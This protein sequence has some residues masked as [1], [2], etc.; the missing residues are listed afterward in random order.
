MIS[1]KYP[2]AYDVTEL[3]NLRTTS[4]PSVRLFA[5][6]KG[7]LIAGRGKESISS[8]LN[9]LL[10]DHQSYLDLRYYAQGGG[11]RTSISGFNI[12]D[13]STPLKSL[14]DIYAD[15]MRL[16]RNLAEQK[17]N[18]PG[19]KSSVVEIRPPEI[20]RDSIVSRLSYQRIMPGKV[21]LLA[22]SEETVDFAISRIR[23]DSWRVICL[24]KFNQ[25]V[26]TLQKLIQHADK[27][28]FEIYIISLDGFPVDQRIAFFDQLLDYYTINSPEWR[29]RQV[30]GIVVRQSNEKSGDDLFDIDSSVTLDEAMND[31]QSVKSVDKSDLRSISQAALEGK[32]L[33]TNSFVKDCERVGFYF[34][35]M[36]LELEN[37]STAEVVQIQIRF[38]LSPKIFE[39]VLLYTGI[40]TEMGEEEVQFTPERE[41]EFLT[42]S[43]IISHQI[44]HEIKDKLPTSATSRRQSVINFSVDQ[45]S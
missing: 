31:D 3:I 14:Q 29:L 36:S 32:N 1:E 40:S 30:C 37:K 28:A 8:A 5:A 34:S 44:W 10:L 33:R 39:V 13:W 2:D 42:E 18:T 6:T 21:E 9:R 4:L 20:I 45:S 27:V 12:R 11:E 7:V 25:D 26:D 16:R 24:P 43:W 22:R 15:I 23:D 38:K 19:R 17:Q 35:S 41:Q